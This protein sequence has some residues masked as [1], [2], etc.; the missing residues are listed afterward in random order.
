MK[1]KVINY[2]ENSVLK[3]IIIG[4]ITIVY[5][6][7]LFYLMLPPINPTSFIFWVYLIMVIGFYTLIAACSNLTVV[8]N[9]LVSKKPKQ[10][11]R[12]VY[13]W[14]GF[15]VVFLAILFVNFINSPIFNAK[16]YYERINVKEDGVFETDIK[17]VDINTLPLLD[18]DSSR[19]LGD[20]V[21][22]QMTDL[23][24]QFE[25][26][27][28]YTQI[29]Y[30]NE[31]TRVTPLEYADIIK[32]FTNHNE[33]IKGYIKVNSV[34][35]K[36]ELVRLEKGM[37]YMKSAV[38][39]EDLYR[40]LRFSYLNEIF[41]EANFEIDNDG[42][43]YW[44]VPTLKYSAVGLREEVT[45]VI[46]LNPITGESKKYKTNEIP[47]WVDHVYSADLIIEQLDDWGTY[48]NGFLNSLFG[49]KGVVNTTEGYNY[50]VM[51]DDVY[52]Y[53]GITSVMSDESN[54][55]FVLCN[56]RTKETIFY[57]VSGAEEYSAMD[58]A[59]GQVQQM[60][61]EASFPLLINLN[62]KPTYLLSLKDNAGL[63]KMYALVDVV[64]YQKVVVT[65]SS[66]GI[67]KAINNY[68]GEEIN[69]NKET[70]ESS[71]TIL[72]IDTA[73]ID[74]NTYYYLLDSDNN[75]YKVSIKVN[76]NLLP[77]IKVED[78][79]KVS[80]IEKD[81]IREIISIK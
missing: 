59:K 81:N 33:G 42:N 6:F 58:S 1:K 25:V 26:S 23:V 19:K 73:I 60:D 39:N 17:Q 52:L 48:K 2:E 78:K 50:T 7:I 56:L 34:T 49:Q 37:K 63:V 76:S 46:I 27:D 10:N 74:G 22:G 21:M 71:I 20:R 72:N 28:L 29:N 45:G 16:A 18:K 66:E 5:A 44:I 79:L 47:T 15:I 43:P 41:G 38:F 69:V 53:T 40:K 57:S 9:I 51:N 24:S 67:E 11:D 4:V 32:Y 12:Y 8:G 70:K 31:I 75:K 36:T 64:D 80:Y 62:N 35:G 13:I 61:Y 68:L 54:I 65:D 14:I 77:F 55:G 30:N 3:K